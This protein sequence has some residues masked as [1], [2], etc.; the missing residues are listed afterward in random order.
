MT[1]NGHSIELAADLPLLHLEPNVEQL[2]WKVRVASGAKRNALRIQYQLEGVDETWRE[3]KGPM[4]VNVRWLDARSSLA[5]VQSFYPEGQSEGWTTSW[6]LSPFVD[7]SERVTVPA[8]CQ[9]LEFQLVS[10]IS[11]ILG[12][13]LLDDLTITLEESN[14]VLYTCDFND[15]NLITNAWRPGGLRKEMSQWV[16]R[17]ENGDANGMLAI[18]DNSVIGYSDWRSRMTFDVTRL[19]GKT[20]RM[21]WRLMHD[22]GSCVTSEIA[23]DRLDAG[24]Y[25]FRVRGVHPLTKEPVQGTEL[26]IPFVIPVILWKQTWFLLSCTVGSVLLMW[27]VIYMVLRARW[28]RR[29]EYSERQRLIEAEKTRI[30]RDLHDHLG[31][32]LTQVAIFSELAQQKKNNEEQLTAR[33]DDMFTTTQQLARSLNEIVWAVKPENDTLESFITYLGEYVDEYLRAARISFRSDVPLIRSSR[34]M[35]SSLRHHLF[36]CSREILCNIVRHAEATEVLFQLSLEGDDLQI[37]YSDNGKGFEMESFKTLPGIHNGIM[38]LHQR[39][40]EAG[41]SCKIVSAPSQ[42][43]TITLKVRLQND[44]SRTC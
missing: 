29:L 11:A 40:T 44:H 37:V 10:G 9:Y 15:R 39:M 31:A 8:K 2:R 28:R 24:N 7:Y 17:T 34:P 16:S 22:I 3:L 35:A 18:F 12:T 19:R 20:L 38:N 5:D 43:T 32:G 42:G 6:E 25:L 33:L 4:S 41:G 13:I 1:V 26:T 27:G 30:A 36:C 21:E 23:Y 14:E